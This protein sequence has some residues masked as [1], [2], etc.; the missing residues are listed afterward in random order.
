MQEPISDVAH[1]AALQRVLRWPRDTLFPILDIVRLAVRDANVCQQLASTTAATSSAFL[2]QIIEN[3]GHAPANQLMAIRCI[4]NM[5]SHQDGRD[6]VGARL[7]DIVG[8]VNRIMSGSANLQIAI[9]TLYL[10][11]S[12]TQLQLADA[13]VCRQLTEA[14]LEFLRWTHEPEAF[15]R[16]YQTLGNLTCTPSGAVTSAQIVSV[17]AVV[18]RLRDHMSCVQ[19]AGME[20]L[21]ELARDLTA[22]L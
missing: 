20:R 21:N 10:N 17:D 6:R 8:R 5:L 14:V 22:A 4:A 13:E 15:Y 3:I 18:D 11:A 9:A 1:V 19:P 16:A 12:V 2:D 7:T